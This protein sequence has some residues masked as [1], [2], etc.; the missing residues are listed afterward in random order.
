MLKGLQTYI[1]VAL[2]SIGHRAEL[3]GIELIEARDRLIAVLLMLIAAAVLVLLA[4]GVVTIFVAAAFWDTAYRLH[5]L[6]GLALLY[7][8]AVTF[9]AL[10]LQHLLRT[11]RPFPLT[12]EQLRKDAACVELLLRKTP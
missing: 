3:A 2:R 7:I 5:A 10:R 9:C 1:Q 8:L 11:W 4:G 12:Q 6:G